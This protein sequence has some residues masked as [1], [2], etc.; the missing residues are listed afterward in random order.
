MTTS[1]AKTKT[2]PEPEIAT[3]AFDTVLN[4]GRE[5]AEQAIKAGADVYAQGYEKAIAFNKEHFAGFARGYDDIADLNKETFEVFTAASNA[6]TKGAEEIGN[7]VAC[8]ARSMVQ[9]SIATTRNVMA[10]KTLMDA[11]DAQNAFARNAFQA[12]FDT[13]TK[14]G[15]MSFKV[16]NEVSAPVNKRVSEMVEKF[17]RPISA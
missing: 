16:G 7:E 13:G 5:A 2:T 8:Y 6:A 14:V 9:E 12:F 10:A 17:V 15:E 3:E 4:A 1:K 11:L